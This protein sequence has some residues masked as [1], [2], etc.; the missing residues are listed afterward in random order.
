MSNRKSTQ[1]C[2]MAMLAVGCGCSPKTARA[3]RGFG[4]YRVAVEVQRRRP[5]LNLNPD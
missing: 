3:W 1:W 5:D 2:V 4:H